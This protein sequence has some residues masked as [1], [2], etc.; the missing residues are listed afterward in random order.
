MADADLTRRGLLGG[1]AMVSRLIDPKR[2]IERAVDQQHGVPTQRE[3]SRQIDQARKIDA[4][5]SRTQNYIYHETIDW[6]L[7]N[8]PAN[9][10]TPMKLIFATSTTAVT[11]AIQTLHFG[12]PA[13]VTSVR[14]ISN[15]DVAAGTAK[16][17]IGIDESGVITYYEIDGC[18][19][20]ASVYPSGNVHVFPWDAAPEISSDG[21]FGVDVLTD[22][23]FSP[24]TCD[25]KCYVTL[26]YEEWI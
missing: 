22:A 24:A 1:L 2:H 18:T 14:L 20:D 7:P 8:V 17:K 10:A 4:E 9:T 25:M 26:G 19:L 5:F 3:L 15:G 13:K 12:R 16:P 6:F 11:L 23:A 21:I